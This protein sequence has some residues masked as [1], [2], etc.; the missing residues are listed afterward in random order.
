MLGRREK[1]R[2]LLIS[3]SGIDGA[4]KSTQIDALSQHLNSLGLRV[5]TVVF[6]DEIARL[7]RFRENAGH[8]LFKG[9]KGVGTPD[10]PVERRDKN[11]RSWY[12]TCVRLCLYLVDAVSLRFLAIRV[13]KSDDS[14]VI[15]DRYIYDEL[16]NLS[17]DHPVIRVYVRILL[18]IVPTPHVIYFLDADPVMARARKPEYPIEFLRINRQSYW[19]LSQMIHRVNVISP[20]SIDNAEQRILSLALEELSRGSVKAGLTNGPLPLAT[21]VSRPGSAAP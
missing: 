11:V 4:G 9:D 15:F 21:V 14:V 20:M 7:T 10:A 16:A 8:S 5:R 19:K 6:W 18:K 3:F 17:L 13:R 1:D 2:T 12:M